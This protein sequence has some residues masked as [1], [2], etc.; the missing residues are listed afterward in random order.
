MFPNVGV[1][2]LA[3]LVPMII[4]FLYY[5]PK[6]LGTAWMNAS[7]MT[8]EK[9]KGGNMPLIFGLSLVLSFLLGLIL[10]NSVVHQS[11]FYSIFA[12]SEGFLVDGSEIMDEINAFMTKHGNKFR[13]FK[14][15]ALHGTIMGVLFALPIMATN[16][17]FERK[18]A[19]YIFI[20]AG[21][22]I[23]TLGLMGGVLC[24][25]G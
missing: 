3:A 17:L 15:G 12:G 4:G 13:T 14:H 6:I 16:A 22:W 18:S 2:A 21:Y 20:N 7:G 1:V 23:I 25:W 19:K 5:H 9:M 11:H 10:F 8:E 24:Q